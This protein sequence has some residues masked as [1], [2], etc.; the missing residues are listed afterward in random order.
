MA[1]GMNLNSDS[2]ARVVEL[3]NHIEL[4]EEQ[5]QTLRQ[6][7]PGIK[8]LEEHVQKLRQT[9]YGMDVDYRAEF[10]ELNR[11]NQ[12]GLLRN[13]FDNQDLV[14]ANLANIKQYILKDVVPHLQRPVVEPTQRIGGGRTRKRR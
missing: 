10:Y 8:L 11:R 13:F 1:Y 14:Q 12:Q 6:T 2:E 5:V 9:V 7:V 4:L 3:Q